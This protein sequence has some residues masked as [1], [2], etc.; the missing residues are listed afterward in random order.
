[1]Y[2]KLMNPEKALSSYIHHKIIQD[3]NWRSPMNSLFDFAGSNQSNVECK[4]FKRIVLGNLVD[5]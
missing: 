2:E 5:K 3:T 4:A 1:M